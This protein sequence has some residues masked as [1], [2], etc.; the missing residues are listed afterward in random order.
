MKG[1]VFT[2][3]LEMVE[4]RFGA[5]MVDDVLDDCSFVHD[6]AYTRIGTYDHHELLTIVAALA[7]RTSVSVRDL[8]YT[9]GHHLFERFRV[10]MPHFFDQP[11]NAFEFLE[12][13][14]N[15]VHVEVKKLYSD[16][17]LPSLK[18]RDRSHRTLVLEY[19]S[20]C[21]FADFAHGLICG[22]IDFFDEDIA[23]SY[24]DQNTPGCFGRVFR[25]E[26][27]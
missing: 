5:D 1:I 25:L 7:K 13:V 27:V 15:V 10:M 20:S 4:A 6:G 14:H 19:G 24:E 23:V 26:K 8:V 12:S 16:A 11:Q 9:Y 18:V 2:E 17:Q 3:L 22:C 21:P